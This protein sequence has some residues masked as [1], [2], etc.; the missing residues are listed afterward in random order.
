[1]G[2]VSS[3]KEA[4]IQSYQTDAVYT[5]DGESKMV[6]VLF[7]D[8]KGSMELMEEVDPEEARALVDPALKLMIETA[9]R[10]G[11]FIV[12]PTGSGIFVLFG[13]PV[14]QEDYPQRALYATIRTQK[15]MRG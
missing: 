2:I 3:G 1:M 10:Y 13:A 15:E 9:N 6:T 8:I 4:R 7:A 14:A 5:V 12:Q 11:G